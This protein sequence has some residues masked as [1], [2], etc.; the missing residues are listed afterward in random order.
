[1][2]DRIREDISC[3]FDRD[4]AAR[5]TWEVITC[6][7]GF[8]ALLIHRLAHGFWR[9]KMRWLG[10]FVSHVSRFLTGIEI[11]PGAK[12]GRRVFIDHGMGVV[13]GETAEL[14]DECTL[15]HGVTLGGTTWNKGKRHPT[16]GRG[17]VIG[18][19]AKLL[20]PIVVGD[21]A[22]VGSNAVLV[23]DVPPGATAVGIPARIILDEQDKTREEKAAKLGFSAYAVSAKAE[24][25]PLAKA[26]Q[27][28]L[29][30]SVEM[31]KRIEL[32]LS[33]I[34]DIQA[35][36]EDTQ[37]LRLGPKVVNK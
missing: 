21:G 8:H 11:H 3:V 9:M 23:K 5:S 33:Q 36:R 7:P 18:A 27:G 28:L 24:D 26:V 2:F 37:Q 17:V 20:G 16:L 15:Y 22:R 30:H 34:E 32:I 29:D 1:M 13:I 4:P 12:I 19:G 14:G 35:E 6:Y 10:R 31:D 25:D